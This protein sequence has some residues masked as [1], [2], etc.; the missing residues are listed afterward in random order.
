MGEET[1]VLA[2]VRASA[3]R[4]GLGLAMLWLLGALLLWL[5]LARPPAPE[6]QALLIGLGVGALWLGERMRR[7]TALAVE[8]TGAG[9]V[10]SDGE[11]I[12]GWDRIAGVDRGTFA[13]KPSNGFIVRLTARAPARWRPGLWWRLGRHAGIGGV[14]PGAQAK[15]MAEII[16]ARL[17]GR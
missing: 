6:F 16:A 9:L 14:T 3:G 15:L 11:V 10:C 4:R 17:A 12:A 1:E 5:A 8:L 2:V 7:A 13:F